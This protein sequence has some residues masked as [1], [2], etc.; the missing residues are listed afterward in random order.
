MHRLGLDKTFEEYVALYGEEMARTITQTAGGLEHY[1]AIQHIEMGIA[2]AAEQ[3]VGQTMQDEAH[4]R[5]WNYQITPGRLDLILALANGKWD[6]ERFLI[7]QPG[8]S[9]QQAYDERVI[10]AE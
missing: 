7:V 2:P 1:Q 8:Q 3:R 6:Q 5:G 10:R 9:I 4:R